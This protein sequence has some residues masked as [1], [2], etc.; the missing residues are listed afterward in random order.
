MDRVRWKHLAD[1]DRMIVLLYTYS[2]YTTSNQLP[3]LPILDVQ[4]AVPRFKRREKQHKDMNLLSR[5]L[6]QDLDPLASLH[7]RKRAFRIIK[8]YFPGNQLLNPLAT[9][10]TAVW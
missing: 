5:S 1:W 8:R 10:S 9:R 7:I 2:P 3:S 6:N 4:S